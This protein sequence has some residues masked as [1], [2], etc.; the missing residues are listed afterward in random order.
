MDSEVVHLI[1]G[2][3]AILLGAAICLSAALSGAVLV[4]LLWTLVIAAGILVLVYAFLRFRL[5]EIINLV[6]EIKKVGVQ[7]WILS[8][9]Q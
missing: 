8:L 4:G 7:T 9:G 6:K 2:W 5:P 3:F 1:S